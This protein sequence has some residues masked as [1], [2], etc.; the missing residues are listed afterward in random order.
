[1]LKNIS[2]AKVEAKYNSIL[3]TVDPGG[4]LDVRDFRVS[5]NPAHIDMVE[6]QIIRK[7]PGAFESFKSEAQVEIKKETF[8]RIKALE[9]ENEE[10][11]K[12]LVVAN[13]A[14]EAAEKEARKSSNELTGAL[15]QVK[16]LKEDV[17]ELKAKLKAAQ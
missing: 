4:I 17:K 16:A 3:I 15:D 12:Q 1:M 10:L 9:A 8:D 6:K 13:K 14:K 7:N 2:D 5:S 11:K